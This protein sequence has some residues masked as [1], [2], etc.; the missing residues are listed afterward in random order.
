MNIRTFQFLCAALLLPALL[1]AQVRLASR[2]GEIS[3]LAGTSIE[4]VSALNRKVTSVFIPSTGAIEF[5][6]LI[7]AFEFKRA[8]MEEHFNENYMESNTFPK[9]IFKGKLVPATGEDL[10]KP[11]THEVAVVGDLTIHGVTQQIAAK[12]QL[13]TAADGTA[14]AQ[15][16]FEVKPEDYGIKI[17]GLVRDK[18]AER[19]QVKVR[20]DYTK[21]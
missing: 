6:A 16:E 19:A 8:L 21:L 11:G 4:D 1:S 20:I 7:K 9:A 3:F 17:P 5:A 12:G 15:C 18:I 14:K 13:I 2:N 10:T